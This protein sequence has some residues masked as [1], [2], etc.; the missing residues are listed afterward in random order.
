MVINNS[1]NNNVKFIS[2]TGKYPNLCNGILTL[3]INGVEVSFGHDASYYKNDDNDGNYEPFWH[4]GGRCGFRNH[5]SQSYCEQD[6]WIIDAQELP[7][8]YRKYANEIDEVFNENV[9]Y[10][11]C[12]GCL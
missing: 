4:T 10:G 2:Y 7:E 3:E 6:E 8:K 9:D 11:C 5:Y 12:G 1:N